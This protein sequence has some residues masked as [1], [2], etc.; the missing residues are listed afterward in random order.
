ME[1]LWKRQKINVYLEQH[2]GKDLVPEFELNDTTLSYL[3][4]L[5]LLSEK[6]EKNA[7]LL[8]EDLQQKTVEYNALSKR[9]STV[10]DGL[11]LGP[12]D[13]SKSGASNL[14]TLAKLGDTL[15]VKNA[16]VTNY[17]LALQELDDE[18]YQVEE[19]LSQEEKKLQELTKKSQNAGSKVESLQK[20]LELVKQSTKEEVQLAETRMNDLT[21]Y[22][23]KKANAYKKDID[24]LTQSKINPNVMHESLVKKS[25][26]LAKLEAD[27]E[28]LK[29]ELQSYMVLPPN[30][31]ETKIL[32]EKKKREL[33][34]LD[35]ELAQ[36]VDTSV[37]T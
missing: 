4:D 15:Q 30:L 2:F 27:L 17:Y 18:Q 31:S 37:L 28:P 34:D 9:L 21:P 22:F 12:K 14:K 13:L 26:K 5:A 35:K 33:S 25:Q 1:S 32:I 24:K 20:S 10:L 16:S 36:C 23:K 19:Q 6:N 29:K 7:T 8:L 3:Y 11:C